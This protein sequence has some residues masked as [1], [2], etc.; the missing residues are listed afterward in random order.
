MTNPLFMPCG[1]NPLFLSHC[2]GEAAGDGG[3]PVE[4]PPVPVPVIEYRYQNEP[5]QYSVAAETPYVLLIPGGYAKAADLKGPLVEDGQN[6]EAALPL[7]GDTMVIGVTANGRWSEPAVMPEALVGLEVISARVEFIAGDSNGNKGYFPAGV[8][9]GQ[10]WGELVDSGGDADITPALFALNAGPQSLVLITT[11]EISDITIQ[12]LRDVPRP[13]PVIESSNPVRD[14]LLE[15]QVNDGFFV[16]TFSTVMGE[17]VFDG[18]V[19]YD[20]QIDAT[21]KPI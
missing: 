14:A 7:T 15:E 17:G 19:R 3:E 2:V 10:E 21:L 8:I 16:Y 9:S 5:Y 1:A 18:G 20:F 12:Q 6:W 11:Q 4:L 13:I